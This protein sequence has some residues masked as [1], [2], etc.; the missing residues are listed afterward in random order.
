VTPD[1]TGRGKM[2]QCSGSGEGPLLFLHKTAAALKWQ[3]L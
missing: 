3:R 2:N 1:L